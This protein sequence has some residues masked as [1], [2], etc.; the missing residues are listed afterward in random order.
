MEDVVGGATGRLLA[1]LLRQHEAAPLSVLAA[2]SSTSRTQ[3]QAVMRRLVANGFV[4]K[5]AAGP[6]VAYALDRDHAVSAALD[7][8]S[9]AREYIIRRLAAEVSAF[10]HKPV[11]AVLFGSVARGTAVIGS[12]VDVAV[13][14]PAEVGYEDSVWAESLS[15]LDDM[16]AAVSGNR[17][18]V[19]EW[20]IDEV[21]ES[22]ETNPDLWRNIMRDGVVLCGIGV[23]ELLSREVQG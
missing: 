3:A 12:D 5:A 22:V 1:V 4:V 10:P 8:I 13:V 14:R 11:S 18:S 15:G 23:R 19:L 9:G 7:E 16:A 17:G 6:K 20:G 21:S 2:E